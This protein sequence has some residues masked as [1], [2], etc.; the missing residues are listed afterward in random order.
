MQVILP[1]LYAFFF[2]FLIYK[3]NFFAV[4]S[5][6]RNLIVAV[7]IFKI[8]AGTILWWLY[9][10][11]YPGADLLDYFNDGKTLFNVLLS[12]PKLFFQVIFNHASYPGL[13]SWN[14][15]FEH[16][17]YNDAHTMIVLNALLHFFSFG[18]FHVHTV[19]MCFISLI[20]LTAIYKAVALHFTDGKKLLFAVIFLIPSVLFWSSGVLKEGLLFFG[21]G[22]FLHASNFGSG[23]IYS[24]KKII[25]ILISLIILLLVKFYVFIALIPG[26]LL[27]IWVSRT[28]E[29]SAVAKYATIIAVLICGI[30]LLSVMNP[31]YDPLKII[32]EKQA[33]AISESKGGIFLENEQHFICIDNEKKAEYLQPVK[34]SVYVIKPGSIYLQWNQNNMQDT[35]F[36]TNSTDTAKFNFLYEIVPANTTL[37]LDRLQPTFNSVLKNAPMAFLNVLIQPL[38]WK[39]K[40]FVQLLPALENIFFIGLLIVTILFFKRKV[41]NKSMIIFCLSFVLILYILIGVTTPAVGAIIRYK[42]PALPFLCIALLLLMDKKKIAKTFPA[43]EKWLK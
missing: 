6:S 42:V 33:K 26:L 15:S 34:D 40:G 16:V 36:I 30:V 22:M 13:H 10:Y 4:P 18:Y 43:M 39:A 12:D 31:D 29:K 14:D 9:T 7:F 20:G 32:S 27:N 23:T 17:L 37:K 24:W 35:T 21:M 25:V 11:H 2:V 5:I 38:L 1:M 8:I 28:S 41:E 19:F 3:I